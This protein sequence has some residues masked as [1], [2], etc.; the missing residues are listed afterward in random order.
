MAIVRYR[1]GNGNIVPLRVIQGEDGKQMFVRFST[2]AD[3]TDMSEV[4]DA[5]RNYMGIA[6]GEVAPTDK[7]GYQWIY[8]TSSEAL[9][10]AVADLR[11]EIATHTITADRVTDLDEVL[12]GCKAVTGSYTGA[13][14]SHKVSIVLPFPAKAIMVCSSELINNR[15]M[16][17]FATIPSENG[18][19]FVQGSGG[20][21]T[22]CLTSSI[23]GTTVTLELYD[24]TG[25]IQQTGKHYTYAAWA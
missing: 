5:S 21:G 1:D 9:D 17:A 18:L 11:E 19:L 14:T 24:P 12:A 4:W 16:F 15:T 25:I 20:I 22:T 6:F 23:I 3:G 7:S 10:E 8:I 13:S 2:Y